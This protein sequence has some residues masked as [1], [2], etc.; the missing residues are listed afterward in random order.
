MMMMKY[1]HQA[2]DWIEKNTDNYEIRRSL[3]N[4]SFVSI[5]LCFLVVSSTICVSAPLNQLV[6]DRQ[7]LVD[8][9]SNFELL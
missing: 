6:V 8:D 7:R 4:V 2:A 5:L 3:I 9:K 1:D